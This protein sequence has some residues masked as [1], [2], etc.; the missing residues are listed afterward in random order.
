VAAAFPT[1]HPLHAAQPA[2]FLS[3]QE[4]EVIRSSDV[5]VSFDWLD[6]AGTLKTAFQENGLGEPPDSVRVVH[7]TLDYPAIHDGWTRNH[8]TQ[9]PVDI[10]VLADVDKT[11]AALLAVAP[12]QPTLKPWS[13]SSLPPASTTTLPAPSQHPNNPEKIFISDLAHALYTILPPSSM[14]LP[15]LPTGFKGSDLHTTHPLSYLGR[16]G[17]EGVGSGPGSAVG[18]ALALKH[19]NSDLLPVAILGDG[20]FL[21]GSSAV[22]TAAHHRIP[23]LI[24]VANNKA[25]YNDKHHQAEVARERGRPVANAGVRTK[26]DDPA[27]DVTKLAESLGAKTVADGLVERKGELEGVLRRAVAAV[28]EGKVGLVDVFVWPEEEEE[29]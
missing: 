28:R 12:D 20:D 9:P 8:F 7:V 26:I 21:M 24:I 16:D 14:S 23:L 5:I 29:S 25:Y 11:V 13:S 3:E 27:P 2:L 19:V 22:W 15:R 6:L 10:A 4:I 1:Q 17:G 18:S